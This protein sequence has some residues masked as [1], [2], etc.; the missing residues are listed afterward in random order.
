[1]I[2]LSGFGAATSW[3]DYVAFGMST[4]QMSGATHLTGYPDGEPLF[5][6]TTGGDLY[7]GVMGA[8]AL[9]AALQ[10]RERTGVGQHI[11]FGQVEACSTYLGDAMTAWSL[12]GHDPGRIGNAHHHY[13][14]QGVFECQNERWIAITCRDLEEMETLAGIVGVDA[15]A[16]AL[17]EALP[18]WSIERD[19]RQTMDELQALG[20]AAGAVQNGPEILDDPQ[21]AARGG[22]IVQD[23]PGL[24]EKHYPNQPYRLC[25]T[26]A[27][28]NRRAP[29]LGEHSAEILA[30]LAGLS[31]DDIA[32][33]IIDDVVGTVPMAAR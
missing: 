11:D 2:S 7:S 15:E 19:H 3:R 8:N 21:I 32:E 25:R 28:P 33:L 24:G 27:P 17:L 1:M 10:L 4:E 18:R 26:E 14:L 22:L 12:A 29:L 13:P 9:F 6:G 31:D 16:D 23:R 20:I 30:E 5:T